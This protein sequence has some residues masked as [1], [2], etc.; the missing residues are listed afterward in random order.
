[1]FEFGGFAVVI[2]AA[3]VAQSTSANTLTES[4]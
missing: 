4:D 2:C 1:M 3:V